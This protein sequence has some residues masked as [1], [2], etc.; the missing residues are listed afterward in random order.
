VGELV[1]RFLI[2]GSIVSAFA[3]LG[4]ILNPKSFAG[5]FGAAPSVAIATIS[6]TVARE[7]SGY[8]AIEARSMIIGAIAF[9][10]YACSVSYVIQRFKLSAS[11]VA[12]AFIL[13]WVAVAFGLRAIWLG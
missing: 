1:I 12:P 8:A 3:A 13:L 4:D 7:G 6:L 2:G 11:M 10:V 9:I 5:L